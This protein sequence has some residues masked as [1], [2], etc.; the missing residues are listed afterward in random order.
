MSEE[1]LKGKRVLVTQAKDYMGPAT[2]VLF[3][4]HGAE[5]IADESGGC[6]ARC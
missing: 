3:C 2:I 1:R 4:E 6:P 5:R